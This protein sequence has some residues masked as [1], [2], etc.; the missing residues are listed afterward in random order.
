MNCQK[1]RNMFFL[2][3]VCSELLRTPNFSK[4]GCLGTTRDRLFDFSVP[5]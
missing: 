5:M 2:Q 1:H 4:L 3:R